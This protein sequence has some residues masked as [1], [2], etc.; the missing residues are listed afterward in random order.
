MMVNNEVTAKNS[1]ALLAP[2]KKKHSQW[3]QKPYR[4]LKR[5]EG[6]TADRTNQAGA[7]KLEDPVKS[8]DLEL[9]NLTVVLGCLLP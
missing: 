5:K 1:P 9:K 7:H 4:L 2:A 8:S 6:I 3:L